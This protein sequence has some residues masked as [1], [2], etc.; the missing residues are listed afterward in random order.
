MSQAFYVE[1]VS[2]LTTTTGKDYLQFVLN[3]GEKK[4]TASCFNPP[5]GAE[6]SMYIHKVVRMT[7][8]QKGNYLNIEGEKW[9]VTEWE[10]EPENSPLRKIKVRSEITPDMLITAVEACLKLN[11]HERFRNLFKFMDYKSLIKTYGDTPAGLKVHHSLKG[12]LIQHVYEMMSLYYN[13]TKSALIKPLR[14]EFVVM[15]ILFHDYGKLKEYDLEKRDNTDQMPILGHIYI[16]A[17]TLSN[18][19]DEYNRVIES[20]VKEDEMSVDL[21]NERSLFVGENMIISDHDR[22]LMVHC[23]L[24]HHGQRD[25]GSP[26]VPCIPEAMVMHFVDMI[27]GRMNMFQNTNHMEKNFFLDNTY[28]IKDYYEQA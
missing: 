28:V 5:A 12:G 18:I 24:A 1:Q 27:S 16:S 23:I 25:F 20:A 7:L 19:I 15:A 17:H 14:H 26:V 6:P 4:Q 13:M 3:D 2:Q 10:Q 9:V 11:M 8:V 22:D 21:C